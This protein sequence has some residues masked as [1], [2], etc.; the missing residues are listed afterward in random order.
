[1]KEAAKFFSKKFA[2]SSSVQSGGDEILIQ[3]DVG[4]E[5]EELIPEKWPEIDEDAIE[6]VG[7]GKSK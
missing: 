5:V 4:D 7:D 1:M 6:N 2:C 3:G